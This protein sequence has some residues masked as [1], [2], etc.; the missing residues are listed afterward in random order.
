[1]TVAGATH[2]V[3]RVAATGQTNAF[4]TVIRERLVPPAAGIKS[5]SLA[6]PS[7]PTR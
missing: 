6:E 1:M 7:G 3:P 4:T 5:H 2:G